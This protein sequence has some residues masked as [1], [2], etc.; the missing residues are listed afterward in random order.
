MEKRVNRVRAFNDIRMEVPCTY[1]GDR[2]NPD[3]K[4]QI[5]DDGT[6]NLVIV[7]YT[8]TYEVIQSHADSVDIKA[9]V[10]RCTI[11]GDTSELYKTE[12][13]YA[14]MTIMPKNRAEALQAIAEAE[15]VWNKLPI[16]AKQKFDND[17]SKFFASAFSDEWYKKLEIPQEKEVV[18]QEDGEVNE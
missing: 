9:I 6:E 2:L 7:G 12:G 5:E 10:E 13:F 4:L 11:T 18:K 17:V 3:Y 14:D 16:E 8:D 15:N 1:E